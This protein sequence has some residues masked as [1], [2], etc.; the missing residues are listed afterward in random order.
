MP[1][2]KNFVRSLGGRPPRHVRQQV[3]IPIVSREIKAHVR[4]NVKTVHHRKKD[5]SGRDTAAEHEPFPR[6]AHWPGE[7]GITKQQRKRRC[8]DLSLEENRERSYH[9]S[10][11]HPATLGL[12][13]SPGDD[14]QRRSSDCYTI[15]ASGSGVLQ[16]EIAVSRVRDV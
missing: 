11:G 5:Y 7:N 15:Q 3:P 16:P 8:E 4:S 13:C 1:N 12:T 6:L 9:Y 2:S 14:Y 10:P